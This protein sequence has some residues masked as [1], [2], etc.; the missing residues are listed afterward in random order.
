[1]I[2]KSGQE[3]ASGF[4]RML[5]EFLSNQQLDKIAKSLKISDDEVKELYHK[6]LEVTNESN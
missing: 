5:I 3:D 6:Y 1:M 4:R 2:T